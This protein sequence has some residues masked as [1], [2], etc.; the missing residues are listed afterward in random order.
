MDPSDSAGDY[1]EKHH[2]YA[3]FEH[4]MQQLIINKPNDPI[5]F[6]ISQL[7]H[8]SA[9]KI[10]ILGAPAS[11]KGTQ[12]EYI[13]EK[14]G[15]EHISTG[16]I[17]RDEVKKQSV[18]G[19]NVKKYLDNGALVPDELIIEMVLNKLN[20]SECKTKGWLLDG[21][22]RTKAQALALQ[23]AGIFADKVVLL[24]VPDNILVE[25]VEGR[26]TDPVTGMIY[27]TK[28]NPAPPEIA[29]RLEQR[30]DDTAEKV[31]A[32][33][34]AYHANLKGVRDSYAS[35]LG[36]IDANQPKEKVF[37][38]V[39]DYI[40]R[41]PLKG[42]RN[43][44]RICLVGT[45]ASGKRTQAEM[46]CARH[47]FVHV[48]VKKIIRDSAAECMSG[49][50]ISPLVQSRLVRFEDR[51]KITAPMLKARLSQAD[52]VTN[53]WVLDGFPANINQARQF[54]KVGIN[55]NKVIFLEI[56]E[57]EAKERIAHRRVDPATGVFY[58]ISGKVKPSEEILERL[59]K[60]PDDEDIP[61][62]LLLQEYKANADELKKFYQHKGKAIQA[63]VPEQT[64]HEQIE[65][66][67]RE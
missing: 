32:R 66:F 15:V 33:L 49:K 44:L 53:G 52:C 26:R 54:E 22:P 29:P 20:S 39:V 10:I 47:G 5:D 8:P 28:F 25:R 45:P 46:L 37:A 48:S 27:H 63:S 31:K 13:V 30:S 14:Y 62:N 7:Q 11:G 55:P 50:K 1:L 16:D 23:T 24:E 6:L 43:P 65:D 17:L 67:I 58:D 59:E 64:I 38:A 2:V 12:C 57:V 4:L 42:P 3:L 36:V 61:V 41:V 19:V 9:L 56:S 34:A 60:H 21:F 35:I 18:I 51:D 40:D